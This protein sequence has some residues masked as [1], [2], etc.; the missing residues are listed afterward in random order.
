LP[1]IARPN[2]RPKCLSRTAV[3]LVQDTL[4]KGATLLVAR[5]G[6]RQEPFLRDGAASAGRVWQR[7]PL[8]KL[9][10]GFSPQTLDFLMWATAVAGDQPTGVWKPIAKRKP[11]MG[12][13]WLLT[14]AYGAVR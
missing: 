2:V 1:L 12:D 6:W 9:G 5:D 10:L 14:T 3:N 11:T 13:R 4:A 8:D 7:S